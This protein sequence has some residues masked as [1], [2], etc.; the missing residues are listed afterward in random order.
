[1]SSFAYKDAA[2]VMGS[3]EFLGKQDRKELTEGLMALPLSAGGHLVPIAEYE[4]MKALCF[5]LKTRA[6]ARLENIA[7]SELDAVLAMRN[8]TLDKDQYEA[9]RELLTRSVSVVT[10]GPGTGKS[11]IASIAIDGIR[12]MDPKAVVACAAYSARAAAALAQKCQGQAYTLHSLVGVKPGEEQR[13]AKRDLSEVDIVVIDE[14]F[15]AE[16]SL[17]LNVLRVTKPTTRIMMLGDPQQLPPVGH[18][19]AMHDLLDLEGIA[20]VRLNTAHRLG[21]PSHLAGQVSRMAAGEEPLPGP[22][23]DII[24]LKRS[25]RSRDAALIA[26]RMHRENL[27]RGLTSIVLTPTQYGDAGHRAINTLVLGRSTYQ[28]GDAVITTAACGER[29]YRNGMQGVIDK[30]GEDLVLVINDAPIPIDDI[31]LGHIQPC[32]AMSAHRAQGLEFDRVIL[33]LTHDMVNT[34]SRQ[35]MVSATTR[36]PHCTIIT[37]RG[38][39]KRAVSKDDVSDRPRIIYALR[40]EGWI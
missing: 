32:H 28:P 16:P 26:A 20:H 13:Y 39:L 9:I 2:H 19:R 37:E 5:H 25:M 11:T 3:H 15:S 30:D 35:M 10:G 24:A 18:S 12:M 6:S 7:T 17:I 4:A 27:A 33:V 22:G 1:V 21:G 34:A 14:V 8:I 29:R 23:L 36:A 40:G 31:V 38:C